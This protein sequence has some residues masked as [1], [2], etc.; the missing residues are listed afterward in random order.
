MTE[1]TKIAPAV[2]FDPERTNELT[3]PA[4]RLLAN[5]PDFLQ[6]TTLRKQVLFADDFL[7]DP[8]FRVLP[9]TIA[10]IARFF[11]VHDYIVGNIIKRGDNGHEAQGRIPALDNGDLRDIQNWIDGAVQQ[12]D[13]LTLAQVVEM[14]D[15]LNNKTVTKNA[16]QKVL[17][18]AKI[19]KTIVAHPEEA[20]RMKLKHAEVAR[21]IDEAAALNNV[22]AEFVF[23]MDETGIDD[24]ANAKDKKVLVRFDSTETSTK[25]PMRRGTSHTT[26]VVCIAAD[27]T[28]TKRLV[29][30]REVTVRGLLAGEGW[31]PRKVMF[32]HTAS[33]YI[34]QDVF[35]SWINTIFVPE[36]ERRRVELDM[37][38]QQAFLVMDNCTAHTND[39]VQEVL[40]EHNIV[41]LFIPAHGSHIFQP[42]DRSTFSSFKAMFR[43]TSPITADVQTTRLVKILESWEKAKKTRTIMSS[44]K[45]AGFTYVTVNRFNHISFDINAVSLPRGF[46]LP[47]E[48]EEPHPRTRHTGESGPRYRI[49]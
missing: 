4:F 3:R 1:R 5:D 13:P 28:A 23:N 38:Q 12:Q 31:T 39:D 37:P 48:D 15:R 46:Q 18:K 41:L 7:S 21:Y 16:L 49:D 35:L 42:L 11:G 17:T 29:I 44:F 26:L 45:L 9:I 22:P 40:N 10:E 8:R 20:G 27:G 6:C 32:A 14:L 36:V 47:T 25:Y 34:N 43:S 19:A 30:I 33:G 2:P 24:K